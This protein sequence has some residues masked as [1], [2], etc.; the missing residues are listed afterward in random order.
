MKLSKI[1]RDC[2]SVVLA[3]DGNYVKYLATTIQSII[4][5]VSDENQYEIIVLDGGISE[6]DKQKLAGMI[7]EIKNVQ[8][9]FFLVENKLEGVDLSQV[10]TTQ[11]ITRATYFRLFIPQVL[12]EYSKCIY[13]D[14]DLVVNCDV[15]ELYKQDLDNCL[16]AA[17]QDYGVCENIKKGDP[18]YLAYFKTLRLSPDEKY[19][20][21]GVLIMDLD[22]MRKQ[23][24]K[25]QL[26]NKLEEIKKPRYWDQSIL[27]AVFKGKVK[28]LDYSYNF[29]W[30]F[31]EDDKHSFPKELQ[32]FFDHPKI[33]HYI[34]AFKP[35]VCKRNSLADCFWKY[36]RQTPFFEEIKKEYEPYLKKHQI[37]DLKNYR[38]Y[39]WR[40]ILALGLNKRWKRKRNRFF[41][42]SHY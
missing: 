14:C 10:K 30:Y 8:L 29:Q 6:K 21:A 37:A 4:V 16:L 34:S 40:N 2:V 3:S 28:F 18:D 19:F 11:Y 12:L 33:V 32:L 41:R 7:Q 39:R 25:N 35:W 17:V 26:L 5:N 24:I 9:R 20:N 23:N 38:K 13:L 27:N 15:A 22:E 36:A 1:K 42:L 31:G